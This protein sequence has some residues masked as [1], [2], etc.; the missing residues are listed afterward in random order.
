V[1]P[2]QRQEVLR[3]WGTA[4]PPQRFQ[5]GQIGFA[6]T[7]LLD[8]LPLTEP[9]LL[10]RRHLRH[11]GVDQGGFANAHLSCQ[12]DHPALSLARL[13]PPLL[14]LRQLLLPPD[15]PSRGIGE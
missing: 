13:S 6:S 14:E 8:A 15:Q 1:P 2:Q 12:E 4:E 5:H 3:T 7:I 11:K 10:C 9:D